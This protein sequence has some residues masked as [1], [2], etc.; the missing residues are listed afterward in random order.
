MGQHHLQFRR[1]LLHLSGRR[2]T[3]TIS[4]RRRC[5]LYTTAQWTLGVN[6]YWS[7]D[8]FQF[9]GNSDAIEGSVGYAFQGKLFNFFSP[10]ISG[11][12]GFQSYEENADDYTYWNAGLTLGFMDHWS[13]DVRYYDTDYN[14]RT[15]LRP[16]WWAG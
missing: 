12:L 7:P 3:S 4:K 11:G 15:V 6:N 8:N 16:K 2:A 1:P 5:D 14:R 13:A 9:F 10:T